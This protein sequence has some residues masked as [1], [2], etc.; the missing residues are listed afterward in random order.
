MSPVDSAS[1][2]RFSA[3]LTLGILF[4]AS[5]TH[6]SVIKA[7]GA[8]SIENKVSL[9]QRQI[10]NILLSH[11]FDRLDTEQVHEIPLRLVFAEKGFDLREYGELREHLKALVETSVQW[12]IYEKDKRR[13]GV[14]TLLA[15][16]EINET[17]GMLEYAFASHLIDKLVIPNN[18]EQIQH[19]PYAKLSLETQRKFTSKHTQ[20]LYEFLTD[21]YIA[22]QKES[23][24]RWIH[25]DEYEQMMNTN[26]KRWDNI[27]ARIIDAPIKE[28][29]PHV[30]FHIHFQAMKAM[31]KTTHIRFRLT[32]KDTPPG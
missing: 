20:F 32:R 26:Y 25:L 22:R 18:R 17:T 3:K 9:V 4:M 31:R 24:T 13:W 27:R 12:N 30:P 29:A 11:A 23:F 15:S 16:A 5:I 8:I 10:W 14:A 2:T 21:A 1:G 28:L 19:T 6:T 7:S